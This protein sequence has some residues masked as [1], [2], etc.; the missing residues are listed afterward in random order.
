V[1]DLDFVF[2]PI[3]GGGLISGTSIA[4]KG[5]LP[6][7]RIIGVEPE[8]VNDAYLSFIQG[9][10]VTNKSTDTIADGLRTNLCERT[11][12]IIRKNVDKIV[13][14]SEEE[15]IEAMRFLWERMKIVVEPSGAVSLAGLLKGDVDVKGERVGVILS[16]GNVDL[17]D[18]FRRC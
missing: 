4:V 13:L 12:K 9:K 8:R 5:L 3:G 11:F 18:F 2:C 16:G 15:I 1:K 7:A 14:V 10:I 17:E 6:K